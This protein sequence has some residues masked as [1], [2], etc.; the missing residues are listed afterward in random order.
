MPNTTV[1]DSQSI[2]Q[3]HDRLIKKLLDPAT[4]DHLFRERLPSELVALM[5]PDLPKP[6]ESSVVNQ[7]LCPALLD[8]LFLIKLVDD[9]P[10][11][12]HIVIEHKSFPDRFHPWQIT[13]NVIETIKQELASTPD[14][15]AL[16]LVIGLVIRHEPIQN[17]APITT[18]D[19]LLSL[20]DAPQ[21]LRPW[22]L[23]LRFVVV[24]LQQIDDDRLS[25]HARL[26][27]GF[28]LLKYGTRDPETQMKAMGQIIAALR[29]CPELLLPAMIYM[30]TVFKFMRREQ[31]EEIVLQ[32]NPEQEVEM[33]S[34]FAHASSMPARWTRSSATDGLFM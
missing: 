4:T 31:V 6:V 17:D 29:Q 14:P 16:P 26:R 7:K 11:Y 12:V 24:H 27:A 19:E 13:S 30:A 3:P 33:L 8:R 34:Q 2:S 22:L 20:V 9:K 15:V 10:L 32:V 21:V 25:S 18:T 28:M 5:T 1:L 23:N